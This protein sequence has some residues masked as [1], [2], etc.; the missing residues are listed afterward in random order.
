MTLNQIHLGDCRGLDWSGDILYTDPPYSARVHSKAYSQSQK[1]GTRGREFGFDHL[2]QDLM[3]WTCQLAAKVKRWA[4]IYS[5]IESVG[6]WKE[7]LETAGATYIRAL[8][9]VRWSAPQLSG[10]RPPSGCEMLI[11][12]YGSDKGKK[13]WNGPGN[14]TH[15]AHKCLRGGEKHKAEKPLDKCLD[16][17][18]WFSDVGEEIL[19]PFTGSGAIPHA[20]SLLGRTYTACELDQEWQQKAIRRVTPFINDL[21]DRDQEKYRSWLAN[22]EIERAEK[23]RMRAHTDKIRAKLDG[24]DIL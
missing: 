13:H 2:S 7:G 15:M 14:L 21:S 10:D 8:P 23:A 4:L 16:V 17:V 9:W 24:E 11:V 5:D 1:N 18:D 20:A 22:K 6:A 3:T 12:A 19:D